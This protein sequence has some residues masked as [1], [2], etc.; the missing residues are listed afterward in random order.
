MTIFQPV[1][2]PWTAASVPLAT[3][4]LHLWLADVEDWEDCDWNEVLSAEELARTSRYRHAV[5]RD[6]A[7]TGRGLLRRLLGRYLGMSPADVAIETGEFGKPQ[8][9]GDTNDTT[10]AFNTSGSAQLALYAF[11]RGTAVGVDIEVFANAPG[12]A[13]KTP[14]SPRTVQSMA[15]RF[16]ADEAALIHG[17]PEAEAAAAFLRFWTCKEACLKCL[18]TGIG[19][20]GPTLADV[21][22]ALNP[23]GTVSGTARAASGRSWRVA[24]LTPCPGST[25]AVAVPAAEATSGENLAVD[26]RQVEPESTERALSRVAAPP[27][28]RAPGAP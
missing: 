16:A 20:G 18:G 9:A 6:R 21:V 23:D 19:G 27:P 17:L 7:R 11:T 3:G 8:L 15:T 14:P 1:I 25:A 5:D 26:L 2:L 4:E 10:I 22:I 28:G 24:S 12:A 13:G